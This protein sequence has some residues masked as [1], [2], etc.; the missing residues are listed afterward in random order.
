[1]F[2]NYIN[3]LR[4]LVIVFIV[5]FHSFWLVK[6]DTSGLL[7]DAIYSFFKGSSAYFLF[8]AGFLFQHLSKNYRYSNYLKK[9]F[10]YVILPYLIIS[11]PWLIK[12]I[13]LAQT[14]IFKDYA[15][16]LQVPLYYLSGAHISPFWFI[17]MIAIFYLCAPVFIYIDRKPRGY[18]LLPLLILLSQFVLRR[19]GL[20]FDTHDPLVFIMIAP[21]QSFTHFLSIYVFGMFCSHYKDALFKYLSAYIGWLVLAF[22]GLFSLELWIEGEASHIE[23][24]VNYFKSLVF[25]M[26]VLYAFWRYDYFLGRKL[27]LIGE[28]SF[29]IFFLHEYVNWIVWRFE[30]ILFGDVLDGTLLNY[31]LILATTILIC[32][33]LLGFAKRLFGRNSRLLVGY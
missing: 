24:N 20:S 33:L 25:L 26:L 10:A 16:Y 8:I 1:M 11:I 30:C 4:G 21:S 2:L 13:F 23:Q 6:W 19:R 29:G 15:A 28:M 9:K 27:A 32:V 3:N 7:F 12:L 14:G 5:G 18:W 22:I 31:C 17:P